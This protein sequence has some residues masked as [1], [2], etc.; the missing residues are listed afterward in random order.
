MRDDD[1]DPRNA[2][3]PGWIVAA[4]VGLAFAVIVIIVLWAVI[5]AAHRLNA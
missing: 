4:G 3:R 2:E 1:F 5:V